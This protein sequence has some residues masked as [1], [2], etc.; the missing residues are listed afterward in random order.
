MVIM[1]SI[2]N[3]LLTTTHIRTQWNRKGTTIQIPMNTSHTMRENIKVST[4]IMI[5]S[6]HT[7]LVNMKYIALY[8]IHWKSFQNIMISTIHTSTIIVWK[9]I[10]MI[11]P[12]ELTIDIDIEILI[13]MMNTAIEL[14][15]MMNMSTSLIL[16]NIC[17]KRSITLLSDKALQHSK[18]DNQKPKETET[19]LFQKINRGGNSVQVKTIKRM[20]NRLSLSHLPSKSKNS[21]KSSNQL[22]LGNTKGN[23]NHNSLHRNNQF[24]ISDMLNPLHKVV[25]NRNI[26]NL[27]NNPSNSR[28]IDLKCSQLSVNQLLANNI[29]HLVSNIN[30]KD[31]LSHRVS[32]QQHHH[33]ITDNRNLRR[34]LKPNL[35]S[36]RLKS[37]IIMLYK[38]NI[39]SRS[40]PRSKP[41]LMRT[42]K[43]LSICFTSMK[44]LKHI[45][46][47]TI[48]MHHGK[49]IIR[50]WF[51]R[52]LITSQCTIL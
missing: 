5:E 7:I 26:A 27:R 21:L 4:T 16:I 43:I 19:L 22:K 37:L 11:L 46:K 48:L 31:S 2:P 29:L 34:Q 20:K 32:N 28:D 44:N 30:R 33:Y 17:M 47:P 35:N 36:H 51:V 12:M 1:L 40:K 50:F 52:S 8:M 13:T 14:N 18:R 23:I 6:I 10:G 49:L 3:L 24:K 38:T 42:I 9:P 41:Q 45:I 39:L 15:G 25:H